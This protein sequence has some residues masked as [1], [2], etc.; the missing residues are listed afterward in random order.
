MPRKHLVSGIAWVKVTEAVSRK[1]VFKKEISNTEATIV[2]KHIE[3][4]EVLFAE[5]SEL[6]PSMI[7]M[8]L[9]IEEMIPIYQDPNVAS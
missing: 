8:K 2:G 7:D 5:C 3:V 1:H 4:Y 9:E 6:Y